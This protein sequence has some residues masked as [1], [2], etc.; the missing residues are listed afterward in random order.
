[1]KIEYRN[2]NL[3]HD[4]ELT[5][6]V[7]CCNSHGAMNSGFAKEL[8]ERFPGAFD[9]YHAA[10]RLEQE[11]GC[12]LS[13]G[14]IIPYVDADKGLT[15]FN[16]VGQK[17]YGRDAKRYASYDAIASGLEAIDEAAPDL[18]MT[19]LFMPLM[20]AVLA[21]GSWRVISSN[22]EVS[23]TNYQPIVYLFDGVLPLT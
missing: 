19:R 11:R 4:P 7:H 22:I 15:I 23:S 3:F 18:G 2:G 8:R 10:Y 20:G 16:L 13:L 1:M 14:Q 12:L 17:N 6:V 9:V 5:H 21:G